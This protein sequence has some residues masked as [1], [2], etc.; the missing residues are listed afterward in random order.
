MKLNNTV[1]ASLAVGAFAVIASAYIYVIA[2]T[3]QAALPAL[4]N[5]TAAASPQV[6]TSPA[7]SSTAA[8]SA[9]TPS[10]A[11][12]ATAAT[13]GRAPSQP[14][15]MLASELF[16][17]VDQNP[18][19]IT[20]IAFV[21]GEDACAVEFAD[22][23]K[24]LVTLPDGAADDL[25][26]RALKAKIPFAGT[27]KEPA[28]SSSSWLV[29]AVI[30]GACIVGAAFVTRSG[31]KRPG[32]KKARGKN[33]KSLREGKKVGWDDIGGC[34]E[35]VRHFKRLGRWTMR[36]EFY[37][38][39]K[40]KMPKGVLVKGPPGTGKTLLARILCWELDGDGVI[41]S[42]SD[43]VEMYVGV[44]AARVREIFDPA[45]KYVKETGK[46]YLIVIDEIDAV[47]GHRS[48]PGAQKNDEREQTLNALLV[49]M[50][51]VLNEEGIIVIGMTNR[52]DMLDPALVRP[53]RLEYHIEIGLPD[54]SGRE[55]ILGIHMEG[56]K[57]AEDATAARLAKETY[58]MSGADLAMIVNA[59]A[60][61]AADRSIKAH[62]AANPEEATAVVKPQKK[63]WSPFGDPNPVEAERPEVTNIEVSEITYADVD[64]AIEDLLLGEKLLSKQA[65]LRQRDKVETVTHEVGH[66]VA[67]SLF[68]F[69]DPITLVSAQRRT[70]TLGV[71]LSMPDYE[72]VSL[73]KRTCLA[74]IVTTLA[75]RR[76]QVEHLGT[77]DAG[78][79][80]D[81]QQATD[82]ARKMVM[83]WG[84]S[85][86]GPMS[87]AYR[88]DGVTPD[89]SE[90]LKAQ[91]DAEWRK[92]VNKADETARYIIQ[93]EKARMKRGI[94]ELS[95]KETI[96]GRDWRT[97][98]ENTPS[99]IV[100][101][102][103]ELF[104]E[105]KKQ[106]ELLG[107][108]QNPK[109]FWQRLFRRRQ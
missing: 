48:Q 68:P 93:T 14:P 92:I 44:G 104:K 109:S 32:G 62:E 49:E 95:A 25:R 10:A 100:W 59:A 43:F 90:S 27:P 17:I 18:K 3:H 41:L 39:H 83:T 5:I 88:S 63:D 64:K 69:Y 58:G 56:K 72:K 8:T 74:R 40:A 94:E 75:G 46:P 103:L 105:F 79:Q 101:T 36:K 13:R 98:M 91:I 60:I 67:Q 70:K 78:V 29:P 50:D 82:L 12:P 84:M 57:I 73:D 37:R 11:T 6:A 61:S 31:M 4:A 86:L 30:I 99:A 106:D 38:K 102:D 107:G 96:P 81:Y 22:G 16:A 26:A 15:T 20:L 7:A 108:A 76:A 1:K 9:P 34:P 55:Q 85:D 77:E 97:L 19:S 21:T 45:R 35:A 47:G 89:I 66:A 51:G 42:G 33:L 65:N 2:G 28:T 87:V 24:N 52:A 54:I 71:V 53:G 23:T 80:M